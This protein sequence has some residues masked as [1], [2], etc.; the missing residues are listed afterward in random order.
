MS[1]ELHVD[2]TVLPFRPRRSSSV[3]GRTIEE[4]IY[5]PKPAPDYLPR[6]LRTS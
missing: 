6:M 1:K 4:S 3:A 2:G 5:S